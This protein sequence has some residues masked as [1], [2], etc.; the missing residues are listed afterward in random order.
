MATRQKQKPT[1]PGPP[2]WSYIVTAIVALGG[3][4]WGVI[5]YFVPK[6]EPPKPAVVAPAEPSVSV[7]VSGPGSVGVGTMTG[8][9]I[10]GGAATPAVPA[11]ATK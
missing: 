5:S 11:A 7:T 6:P 2:Q 9:Q 3:L 1:S 10:T 8:G 4:A